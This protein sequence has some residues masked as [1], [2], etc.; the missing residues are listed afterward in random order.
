MNRYDRQERVKVIGKAGQQKIAKV[1]ILIAGVGALGSYTASQLVRAGVAHLILIDPDVVS[2]TNLQRQALFT[3]QDVA[4]GVFKVDAAKKH[5]LAINHAVTIDVYPEPLNESHLTDLKFDLVLDCLDNFRTRDF[6]NKMALKQHFDYIFASCAGTFGSVMPVSP[7]S[8]A[9]LSCLYPNLEE[10]KQTDCDL[11]GV[12]TAL[13]PLVSGLQVSLA[14]HYL[15]DK[16]SVN[17]EQLSTIDNWQMT[18]QN[19]RVKKNAN[20]PICQQNNW[21]ISTAENSNQVTVL[22]GT[23]TYAVQMSSSPTLENLNGWLTQHGIAFRQFKSFSAFT[24]SGYS[25]SVFKTGKVLMYGVP[26]LKDA[27]AIYQSLT[28]ALRPGAT[29]EATSL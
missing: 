7:S 27:T 19:F 23:K 13:V 12:N 29:Q 16:V 2:M 9:C 14:I 15:V 18:F 28:Q 17:F 25:V 5:L 8:H 10:L 3:E 11:I 21:S 1:T 6:L 4:D 22:C 26:N 24:W 20:C